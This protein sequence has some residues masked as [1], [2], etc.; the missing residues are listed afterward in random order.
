MALCVGAMSLFQAHRLRRVDAALSCTGL[1]LDLLDV[2]AGAPIEFAGNEPEHG[3]LQRLP[4]FVAHETLTDVNP[5][6]EV[7]LEFDAHLRSVIQELIGQH[8]IWP[9]ALRERLL[10]VASVPCETAEARHGGA[11]NSEPSIVQM[12]VDHAF[13]SPRSARLGL[14]DAV[15]YLSPA[16][17]ASDMG[18][19]SAETI[20][21]SAPL[22]RG[23]CFEFRGNASV[24]FRV[25]GAAGSA[26]VRYVSI[27]QLPRRL[28]HA[29]SS[30]PRSFTVHAELADRMGLLSTPQAHN[31]ETSTDPYDVFLGSFEYA[32]AAPALQV[33]TLSQAAVVRGLRVSF[34]A[35]GWN[36]HSTCVHRVRA[37]GSAPRTIGA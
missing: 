36:G 22:T 16:L 14:F 32:I 8:G 15:R 4:A 12:R 35:P 24:A 18:F 20:I 23:N 37:H 2:L 28:A 26:V 29:Q 13:T 6:S 33:F 10:S 11:W 21:S 3:S 7:A 1:R 25:L 19:A 17:G 31:L 30:L 27:E 9:V 34:E 5:N